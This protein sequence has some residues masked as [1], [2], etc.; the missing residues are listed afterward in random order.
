MKK[1]RRPVQIQTKFSSNCSIYKRYRFSSLIP[2]QELLSE[3][4]K[5]QS[6]LVKS[7]NTPNLTDISNKRT[8]V[9]SR[10]PIPR[11]AHKFPAVQSLLKIQEQQRMKETRAESPL[12]ELFL[13]KV[14]P[15]N[16]SPLPLHF[17]NEA[18]F[19]LASKMVYSIID[20]QQEL[21]NRQETELKLLREEPDT[22][23]SN[24]K[25]KSRRLKDSLALDDFLA[26]KTTN[27]SERPAGIEKKREDLE[28]K[29]LN[30]HSKLLSL[31]GKNTNEKNASG[32]MNFEDFPFFDD[33]KISS[34]TSSAKDQRS[35]SLFDDIISQ[36]NPRG[37]VRS[38]SASTLNVDQIDTMNEQRL[39]RLTAIEG[40][41][42]SSAKTIEETDII[43]SFLRSEAS[44]GSRPSSL[45]SKSQ[46]A[47][48]NLGH[49]G[50]RLFPK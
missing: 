28:H 49:S 35:G 43:D 22:Y 1:Y 45:R 27:P 48:I 3:Q 37:K 50:V 23:I 40:K 44:R 12:N 21:I 11:S 39:K 19:D 32:R 8:R 17:E 36:F 10:N 9:G 30:S 46:F 41:R 42:F 47:D 20:K 4:E 5:V 34:A 31:S 26:E 14:F 13:S 33:V 29:A 6:E 25:D 16:P 24:E 18:R 2:L 7:S 38:S 15:P